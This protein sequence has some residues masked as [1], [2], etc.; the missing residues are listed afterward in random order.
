LWQGCTAVVNDIGVLQTC[1]LLSR[2]TQSLN[3]RHELERANVPELEA[4]E[5][6]RFFDR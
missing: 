1:A 3:S 4:R 2:C 5:R 6:A